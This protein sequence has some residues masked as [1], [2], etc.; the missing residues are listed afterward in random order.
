MGITTGAAE[1]PHIRP[2]SLM[3]VST[4]CATS[5][6]NLADALAMFFLKKHDKDLHGCAP[7]GVVN[8]DHHLAMIH[9]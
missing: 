9:V 2:H 5:Q 3:K 1:A 6:G 8:A 7:I 4:S